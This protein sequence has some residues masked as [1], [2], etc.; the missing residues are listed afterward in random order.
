MQANYCS[1]WSFQISMLNGWNY[2]RAWRTAAGNSLSPQLHQRRAY[3][4]DHPRFLKHCRARNSRLVPKST[5]VYKNGRLQ[6]HH[7]TTLSQM[8]ASSWRE[9]LHQDPA[10]TTRRND[11]SQK[12]QRQRKGTTI[13]YNSNG[14]KLV[15]W[16]LLSTD[17]D[18]FQVSV[19]HS[20]ASQSG[21]ASCPRRMSRVRK[22]RSLS[23]PYSR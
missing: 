9:Q 16:I 2:H 21:K 19:F 8:Q 4:S 17:W 13:A 11:S 22:G 7:R 15:K 6:D 14:K 12:K 3:M 5:L 10:T 20:E 23:S 1:V 18:S